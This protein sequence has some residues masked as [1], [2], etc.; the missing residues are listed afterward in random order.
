MY[1]DAIV[2]SVNAAGGY[3]SPEFP[4]L[5]F[6]GPS[7]ASKYN[8]R[9]NDRRFLSVVQSIVSFFKKGTFV[10]RNSK[11]RIPRNVVVYRLNLDMEEAAFAFDHIREMCR[12]VISDVDIQSAPEFVRNL[13][14]EFPL[15]Y[16]H[17]V[18][19]GMAVVSK[20]RTSIVSL[21]RNDETIVPLGSTLQCMCEHLE[22]DNAWLEKPSNKTRALLLES[23]VVAHTSSKIVEL[24]DGIRIDVPTELAREVTINKKSKKSIANA[25]LVAASGHQARQVSYHDLLSVL[26]I[27]RRSNGNIQS[28]YSS[29]HNPTVDDAMVH[30]DTI[31]GTVAV[32]FRPKRDE[33]DVMRKLRIFIPHVASALGI[34]C[35]D[36]VRGIISCIPHERFVF[37]SVLLLCFL[38]ID[39]EIC[40]ECQEI[41]DWTKMAK[42][43]EE[44]CG[45]FDECLKSKQF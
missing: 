30:I 8:L 22:I 41:P 40:S 44:F 32:H 42:R 23:I 36:V 14:T 19:R 11:H 33:R 15:D 31:I 37:V 18:V 35:I 34:S 16:C 3:Y 28:L 24:G 29:L 7:N 4:F 9:Y 1:T 25:M 10:Y 13:R 39:F 21:P 38:G 20:P 12:G 17:G 2:W 45:W 5:I 6:V 26:E 43:I 27:G